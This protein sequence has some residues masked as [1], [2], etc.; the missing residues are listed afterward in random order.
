MSLSVFAQK[1][2]KNVRCVPAL[3]HKIDMVSINESRIFF[4]QQ[5]AKNEKCGP[6]LRVG[7]SEV[8]LLVVFHAD[9][10]AALITHASYE[11]HVLR[12]FFSCSACERK[13]ILR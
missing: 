3:I 9:L 1:H 11:R 12:A 10:E 2:R 4:P 6:P 7:V 5:R 8:F 13:K